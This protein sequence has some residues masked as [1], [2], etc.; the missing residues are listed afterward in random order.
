MAR[1]SPLPPLRACRSLVA[2]GAVGITS[3]TTTAVGDVERFLVAAQHDA[4]GAEVLS[5]TVDLAGR[6]N[7]MR[8][9]RREVD[10][11]RVDHGSLIGRALPS[12]AVASVR[13]SL[14]ER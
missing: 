11:P 10:P 9:A 12:I 2:R 13:R 1:P 8:A 6:V 14:V 4:V 5:P 3:A 7:V